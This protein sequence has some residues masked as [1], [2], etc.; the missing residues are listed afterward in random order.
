MITTDELK[1]TETETDYVMKDPLVILEPPD[2]S[3]LGAVT[4]TNSTERVN[5][6]V[7]TEWNVTKPHPVQTMVS[8]TVGI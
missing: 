1:E 6:S 7:S 4:I 8:V 3:E 2:E 5:D